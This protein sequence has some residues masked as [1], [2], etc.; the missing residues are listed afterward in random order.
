MLHAMYCRLAKTPGVWYL[1]EHLMRLH[2]MGK[3]GFDW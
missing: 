2:R 3:V 1:W